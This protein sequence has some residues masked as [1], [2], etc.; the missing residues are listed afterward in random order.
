MARTLQRQGFMRSTSSGTDFNDDLPLGSVAEDIVNLSTLDPSAVSG[1]LI[2][3]LNYL[4]SV[5]RDI[6]GDG[7]R[8]YTPVDPDTTLSGLD[9]RI[10]DLSVTAGVDR[11]GW[12][13]VTDLGGQSGGIVSDNS[14]F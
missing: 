11:Q 14:S 10:T 5:E 3:D 7:F 6:K 13:Y 8:W 4:R 9:E 1:T 12:I 2:E